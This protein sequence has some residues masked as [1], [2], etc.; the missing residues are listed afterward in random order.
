MSKVI[1][2][3]DQAN[4][5]TI[6]GLSLN[7]FK[8][9][10]IRRAIR[11]SRYA[12]RLI[13]ATAAVEKPDVQPEPPVGPCKVT[14]ILHASLPH[15]TG[16]Y[17]G[18]AQGL[19]HGLKASGMH[20]TA[21]TR[22]GFYS[23]SVDKRASFPVPSSEVDDVRYKH[24]PTSFPRSS[25]E[26]EYMFRSIEKYK[27][28]FLAE[29]P[30]VVHVRST[31]LIAL[32]ALIAAH[33][34][35]LPVLYEVSGLWELVFEG[36]GQLG[37]ANRI[38]RMEDL[39]CRQAQRVVSMN[40]SMADLLRQR[41]GMD[42]EIGLVPNAVNT[43]KFRDV[44]RLSQIQ[45]FD[46]EVGYVGSLVDYEGLDILLQA[47]ALLRDEGVRVRAKIV[48]RG[49]EK[50]RLDQQLIDLG[51]DDRVNLTGPVSA[52]ESVKQFDNVNVVV[53]PRRSTPATECVTPLKP[54]EAMAAGRPL[55]VSSVSALEEVSQ[56]GR[57]AEVFEKENA[58]DL[59]RRL[60]QLLG[61]RERQEELV[62]EAFDYVNHECNWERIAKRMREELLQIAVSSRNLPYVSSHKDII[63]AG[64]LRMG[65]L[66]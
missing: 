54:F 57:L 52:E 12:V 60:V 34:L 43:A 27:Q 17:T 51:I 62:E 39:V 41:S 23:E 44:P 14:T 58:S 47:I 64:Q 24:L 32:P 65:R 61:D 21:Y 13:E 19:L 15:H 26:F 37:R 11:E 42:S 29:R 6:A 3:W 50:D 40:Q 56:R 45:D 36:R 46:Y 63:E 66:I 25:G 28:V 1:D 31:Y 16:G 30:N 9:K 33:E 59:A 10:D 49:A 4:F 8:R 7:R 20:V 22:P 18:R 48:G 35:N 38:A 53:L 55:L 2:A 5:E